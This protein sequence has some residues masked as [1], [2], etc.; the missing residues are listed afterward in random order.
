MILMIVWQE[1][2]NLL[3]P[4]D[5]VSNGSTWVLECHF[6]IPFHLGHSLLMFHWAELAFGSVGVQ[7]VP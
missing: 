6:R 2:T 1:T 4:A 3:C 5:T 7:G